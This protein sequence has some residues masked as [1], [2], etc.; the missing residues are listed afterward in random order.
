MKKVTISIPAYNEA[1]TLPVVIKKIKEVMNSQPYQSHIVVVDDGSRDNT[2]SVAKQAGAHVIT[3]PK[4][5]GLAETFRTELKEFLRSDDDVLVHIDADGQYNP[6]DIPKLLNEIKNGAD[7]VLGNRFL[8]GIQSMPLLK[9]WGNRAF[10]RTISKIIKYKVGDS[11]TGFRA[12]THELAQ[13]IPITSTHTYTQEQIIRAVKEKF[14]V[15]EVPV[16]FA[17]REGNSRL[18]KHPFE[19]AIKAW[20]NILRIYRDYEPLRFFGRI[21]VLFVIAGLTLGSWLIYLFLTQG[22]IGHIPI[23]ILTILLI[24]LGVQVI[25]FGFLADMRKQ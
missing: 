5:Y 25:L 22:R 17:K 1:A 20:I 18:I 3:H 12:F 23:T 2:S 7:L 11:Q 13:A 6:E 21:G 16:F 9:R 8:G 10:S 24:M 14:K 19:Y 15:K 4:N